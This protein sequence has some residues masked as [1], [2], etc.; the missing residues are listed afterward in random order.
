MVYSAF[1]DGGKYGRGVSEQG[2][3]IE[4]EGML[5]KVRLM[6]RILSGSGSTLSSLCV[7]TMVSCFQPAA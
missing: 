3:G 5:G 6:L 4:L 1:S 7:T 2:M